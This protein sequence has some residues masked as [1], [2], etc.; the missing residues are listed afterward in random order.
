M[1]PS[2]EIDPKYV[3]LVKRYENEKDQLIKIQKKYKFIDWIKLYQSQLTGAELE[4]LQTKICK[5]NLLD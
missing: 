1:R 4:Y 3:E 2:Y 5:V